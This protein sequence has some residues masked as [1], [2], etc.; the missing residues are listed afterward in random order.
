MTLSIRG[1]TVTYNI[2]NIYIITF[3]I[4]A[5]SITVTNATLSITVKNVTPL[6]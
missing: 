6:H 3:I 2:A 4:V 5:L 1:T